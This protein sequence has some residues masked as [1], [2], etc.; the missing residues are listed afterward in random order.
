MIWIDYAILAIVG[1]SGVISLM[2]GFIREALSLAGWIAAFW[3][4]LAFSGRVA[5]WLDG[6]VSVPS[7]RVGIAFAAIFFGVLLVCGIVLRLAGLLVERTGMSGTDRTLGIVFGVLRG[8][9][10][11]GLLVLLAG[12]TP[13]PLDPWWDQ[14]IFLPHF[15]ELANE[16]R[17]FLPPEIQQQIRFG[18]DS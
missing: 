11:A 12:L 3:I 18:P 9:V 4:A 17:A 5:A 10:I 6:Y 16:L 14:S 2:R 7:V 15:V 1:I 13:L 8:I